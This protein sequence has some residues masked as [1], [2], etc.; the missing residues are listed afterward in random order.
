MS[1]QVFD[2]NQNELLETAELRHIL[3]TLGAGK[4]T[5]VEI[6]QLL[7]EADREG[8]GTVDYKRF[9]QNMTSLT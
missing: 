3:T 6:E 7:R 5:T 4:L 9:V 8:R 1:V 2:V